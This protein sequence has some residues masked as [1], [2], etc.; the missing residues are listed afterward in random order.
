MKLL[1]CRYDFV[2]VISLCD[3]GFWFV[4]KSKQK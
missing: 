1:L 2:I 3:P 4:D